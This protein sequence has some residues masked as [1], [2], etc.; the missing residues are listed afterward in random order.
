MMFFLFVYYLDVNECQLHHECEHE[1]IDVVGSYNCDCYQ[2]YVLDDDRRH[3]QFCMY[4]KHFIAQ[5]EF[6]CVVKV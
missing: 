2:G 4:H 5:Y 6:V 1:C 3:C